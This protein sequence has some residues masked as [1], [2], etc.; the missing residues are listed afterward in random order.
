MTLIILDS[1][2]SLRGDEASLALVFSMLSR[3]EE[4]ASSNTS[5]SAIFRSDDVGLA[6]A[7]TN[8]SCGV[9]GVQ[10]ATGDPCRLLV[11]VS[12][13]WMEGSSTSSTCS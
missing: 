2:R 7:S 3:G 1:S 8:A 5:S 12:G 9:I 4:T 10:C 13:G 11:G 6:R